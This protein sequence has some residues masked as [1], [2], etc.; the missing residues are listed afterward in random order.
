MKKVKVIKRIEEVQEV[1]I[2]TADIEETILVL[3]NDLVKGKSCTQRII[4]EEGKIFLVLELEQHMETGEENTLYNKILL[5]VGDY[6]F[7]DVNKYTNEKRFHHIRK[8]EGAYTLEEAQK[9]IKH[10]L[11]QSRK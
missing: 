6:I 8:E 10:K 9:D 11:K 3:E 2:V 1:I 7:E 4:K 5:K